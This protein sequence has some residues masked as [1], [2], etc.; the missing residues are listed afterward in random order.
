MW[1]RASLSILY[2]QL[3]TKKIGAHSVA[4]IHVYLG[5][6]L[7]LCHAGCS[8]LASAALHQSQFVK[9]HQYVRKHARSQCEPLL[10]T[11]VYATCALLG[12]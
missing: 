1:S 11:A 12:S 5:T 10:P 3:Y 8:A 6:V 2:C 7:L 4:T 9:A